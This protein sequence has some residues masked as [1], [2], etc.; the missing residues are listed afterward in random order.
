MVLGRK[1]RPDFPPISER[2]EIIRR[3]YRM[4]AEGMGATRIADILIEEGVPCWTYVKRWSAGYLQVAQYLTSLP[5]VV[6]KCIVEEFPLRLLTFEALERM[7]CMCAGA[8]F[9]LVTADNNGRPNDNVLIEVGLVSGR[10]G[11]TR[12]AI[13]TNGGVHLLSDLDASAVSK[14]SRR[15]RTRKLRKRKPAQEHP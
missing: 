8:V 1:R 3:I 9:I 7:L 13:C 6:G 5:G 12:V 2:V 11:R 15:R 10:M 4:A 14:T